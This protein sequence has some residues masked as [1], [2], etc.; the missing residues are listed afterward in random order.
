MGLLLTGMGDVRWVG[1]KGQEQSL[2]TVN[3]NCSLDIQVLMVSRTL[4]HQAMKESDSGGSDHNLVC[5]R[6][7]TGDSELGERKGL[8]NGKEDTCLPSRRAPQ[9][10]S[11]C[12]TQ[13]PLGRA[14]GKAMSLEK[15]YIRSTGARRIYRR[16]CTG[17]DPQIFL[18][19][20]ICSPKRPPNT[21]PTK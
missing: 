8:G 20:L 18:E 5:D 1:D 4:N 3:L 13:L 21:P 2:D 9:V 14:L 17:P 7:M 10:C 16:G 11:M 15:S 12:K 6:E 19:H